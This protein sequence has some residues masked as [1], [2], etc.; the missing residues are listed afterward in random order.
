MSTD[1]VLVPFTLVCGAWARIVLST[2]LLWADLFWW[3]P[4]DEKHPE[5]PLL[6]ERRHMLKKSL[7]RS[8]SAPLSLILH[9]DI[10]EAADFAFVSWSIM[11]LVIPHFPRCYSLTV[12]TPEPVVF[13]SFL[14]LPGLVANLTYLRLEVDPPFHLYD[15]LFE[16]GNTSPLHDLV[17]TSARL[18]RNA[19]LLSEVPISQLKRLTLCVEGDT[20]PS[21]FAFLER[22]YVLASLTLEIEAELRP[23]YSRL[24]TLPHL[25]TLTITDTKDFNFSHYISAPNLRTLIIKES[26]WRVLVGAEDQNAT[27]DLSITSKTLYRNYLVFIPPS[28]HSRAPV[29]C[30]GQ[31]IYPSVEHH[32][33]V[34][35]TRGPFLASG[36]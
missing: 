35:I 26:S 5:Y 14:P 15:V 13:D 23:D 16:K 8:K 11:D 34:G 12:T 30:S 22:C 33:M 19:E 29:I 21:A 9:F 17:L 20:V 27:P 4:Y 18:A 24:I 10:R 36:Q 31:S 25:E 2:P 32:R 7:G 6:P 3:C 28:A 1:E